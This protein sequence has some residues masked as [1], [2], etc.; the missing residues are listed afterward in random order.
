MT[1]NLVLFKHFLRA[2]HVKATPYMFAN[3][4]VFIVQSVCDVLWS[5]STLLD[6]IDDILSFSEKPSVCFFMNDLTQT[7]FMRAS[8][9][10]EAEQMRI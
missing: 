5:R 3:C 1:L 7:L 8:V 4:P 10:S 2:C 9:K 6:L